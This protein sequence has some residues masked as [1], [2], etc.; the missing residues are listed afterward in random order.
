[1]TE[2]LPRTEPS[3]LPGPVHAAV[4]VTWVGS[5][6]TAAVTVVV[7]ASW[8]LVFHGVFDE[9]S[10]GSGN[11]RGWLVGA[12]VVLVLLSALAAGLARGV[13][14]GQRWSYWGL[15]TLSVV[16]TVGGGYLVFF[17][18]PVFFAGFALATV[19]LLLRPQSRAWAHGRQPVVAA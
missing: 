5:A 2:L 14:R 4:V 17:V 6:L 9:F 8:L 13:A 16:A 1:V 15:L 18:V 19:I 10:S 11:P 7:T 12:A 3:G